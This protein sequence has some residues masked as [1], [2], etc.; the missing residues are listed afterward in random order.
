MCKN[1][2]EEVWITI[3]MQL[4][5]KMC[6]MTATTSKCLFAVAS[7][8]FPVPK[9]VGIKW[10]HLLVAAHSI[11]TTRIRGGK[12]FIR[13]VSYQKPTDVLSDN[14]TTNYFTVS[15]PMRSMIVNTAKIASYQATR[16][17]CKDP[18]PVDLVLSSVRIK[19]E[20]GPDPWIAS[21]GVFYAQAVF[22]TVVVIQNTPFYHTWKY[23][24][25]VSSVPELIEVSNSYDPAKSVHT[26]SQGVAVVAKKS[27]HGHI[28][29]ATVKISSNIVKE[30][31]SRATSLPSTTI[32]MDSPVHW[33][34]ISANESNKLTMFAANA[35]EIFQFA[36]QHDPVAPYDTPPTVSKISA[37]PVFGIGLAS[38]SIRPNDIFVHAPHFIMWIPKNQRGHTPK[39]A[40]PPEKHVIDAFSYVS[41]SSVMFSS[42]NPV[43]SSTFSDTLSMAS[44]SPHAPLV[45][46]MKM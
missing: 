33:T 25:A 10:N 23:N 2:P 11:A 4:G 21:V 28:E 1:L 19:T 13:P 27:V 44:F 41:Q 7:K 17:S 24:D 5:P 32:P 39:I 46:S 36:V 31:N 38:T 30:W 26:S 29:I 15:S 20:P 6:L 8:T 42:H 16:I 45:I 18:I 9:N 22:V 40:Y 35:K 43:Y 14:I 37:M 12:R 3:F 34:S